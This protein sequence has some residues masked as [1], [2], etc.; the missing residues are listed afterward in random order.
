MPVV[1]LPDCRRPTVLKFKAAA[2][3]GML[4]LFALDCP[5]DCCSPIALRVVTVGCCYCECRP[6]EDKICF[7]VV[8]D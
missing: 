7:A 1:F 8:F 5:A 3:R 6:I 4:L 2:L